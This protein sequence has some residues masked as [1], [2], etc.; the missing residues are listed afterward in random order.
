MESVF[1][2]VHLM[3]A[4]A[5]II[6]VLIQPAESGGFVGGGNMSNMMKPRSGADTLTRLTTIFAGIFFLTSLSL[7]VIAKGTAP[8]KDIL[9]LAD[10][11]AAAKEIKTDGQPKAP[12]SK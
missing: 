9:Q 8:E 4:I 6:I 2:V 11:A 5:I 12:I 3:V 7:A 10:E 1:L